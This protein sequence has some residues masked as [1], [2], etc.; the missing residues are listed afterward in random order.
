MFTSLNKPARTGPR[1]AGPR[2]A[3]FALAA[4]LGACGGGG[5]HHDPVPPDTP[6]P[7]GGA[8]P[9]YDVIP[10]GF[11]GASFV[12]ITRQGIANG[13]VVASTSARGPDDP[14]HAFLY[15]GQTEVDIG[16]LG[17]NFA[18]ATAVNPCGHVT[19]WSTTAGGLAHAFLYDGTM[20]DLGTLGGSESLGNVISNCNKVT[21]W[22]VTSSGESHAFLY[23]GTALRDLGTFGGNRSEGQAINNVGQIAGFAAGPGMP[24]T[25]PSCTTAGPADR[26][27]TWDPPATT[28]S[29]STSTM[30]AR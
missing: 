29:R 13:A 16:T 12:D 21:G 8:G 23:D 10:L 22:A 7:G 20:H 17:G 26:Y 24:G 5:D 25:T 1:L 4:L 11:P 6:G 19:G 28:R 30:P 2:L 18:R 14:A 27:A 15:N 3:A 9:T